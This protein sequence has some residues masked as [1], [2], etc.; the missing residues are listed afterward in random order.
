MA[1]FGLIPPISPTQ[2]VELFM[3]LG[4][5]EQ[6][7]VKLARQ[8]FERQGFQTLLLPDTPGGV[9]FRILVTIINEA[10]CALAEGLATAKDIDTAM[11]LG[12]NY[13]LGPL[14]WSELLGLDTVLSALQSLFEELGEDR[15]RPHPL[16]RRMVL[17]GLKNWQEL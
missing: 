17:A 14:E 1:A 4:Q 3:P 5:R 9:G 8:Y 12:V 13:P 2:I 6:E 7:M 16:L 15:Y 11:R 10:V